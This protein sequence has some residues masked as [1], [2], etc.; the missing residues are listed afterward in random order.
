LLLDLDPFDFPFDLDAESSEEEEDEEEED[1]EEESDLDPFDPSLDLELRARLAVNLPAPSAFPRRVP[2]VNRS[3]ASMHD[4][5]AKAKK[6][7]K[8]KA[9]VFIV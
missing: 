6:R 3:R 8:S 7:E 4:K 5:N 9:V 2:R 1:E